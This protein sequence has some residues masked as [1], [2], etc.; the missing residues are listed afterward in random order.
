MSTLGVSR[1]ATPSA[2]GAV[3]NATANAAAAITLRLGLGYV[4][5]RFGVEKI[6]DWRGW[7]VV[8]PPAFADLLHAWTGFSVAALLR[9]L[10]YLE[11]VLGLHLVLGFFTRASATGCALILA[12]AV[13]LMGSTGIGVRDA[14][15]L[16]MAVALAIGGGGSWSLDATR[17]GG[18]S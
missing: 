9:G 1:A 11:V 7:A 3:E 5:L 6:L 17:F 16:A 18:S 13:L 2:V 10:G 12:G 4:F 8:L 15:L 14:G